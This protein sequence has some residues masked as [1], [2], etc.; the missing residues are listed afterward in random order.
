[1]R[2]RL[3]L[4]L[5]HAVP[6]FQP[7]AAQLGRLATHIP[8]F[9]LV[10][11][12]SESEFLRALPEAQAVVVWRFLPE[13]YALA[14]GLRHAFT[15]SAGHDPLP[16]DPSGRVQRHFGH[17]HGALMS[18]SL[19][20]MLTFLNRRLGDAQRR[21]AQRLWDRSPYSSIRRLHGQV[22]LFV[23][24]GAIAQR[25]AQTLSGL[26]LVVQGLRRDV[27]RPSPHAQRVFAPD[28]LHEALGL[29]DHVVCVLPADTGTDHLLDGAA[30]SQMK[31]SACLYNLG[32]GNA[33][34]LEALRGALSRGEIAGAFL[35]VV[36]P[37]PL[38][39]DSAL[40]TTPNLYL[41]PHASAISAEYLDLYFEELA[42][43]LAG[44]PETL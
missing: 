34:E 44:L 20:A 41:T 29:A 12:A 17:F 11:V 26:G 36:A 35:D 18:E 15:P 2:S 9:E 23:G 13:W 28:Q 7:T 33:I 3:L 21:Q 10:T 4:W 30:L 14:R 6:A 37:E 32:R 16:D 42:R 8:G 25:C 40:W 19:L 43:E 24:Y 27:S 31:P 1:M 5:S 22:V 39:A 38:P